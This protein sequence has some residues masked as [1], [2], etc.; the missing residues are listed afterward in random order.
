[1]TVRGIDN[2]DVH[3]CLHQLA[4]TVQNVRCHTNACT[5]KQPA[6][7]IL[8]AVGVLDLLLN[9]L[10]GD[11]SLQMA[12]LVDDRKLFLARLSEDL[13]GFLK[14]DTFLRGDQV[15]GRHVLGNLPG[16]ILLELEIAVRDDADQLSFRIH[17]RNTGD[18]VLSHQ[19]FGF[20]KGIVR[21][22]REGIRDDAVLGALD[23][24]DFFRLRFDRH[25]LV[26]DADSALACHSD[27]HTVFRHRIHAGAHDRNVEFDRLCQVC[28][29]VDLVRNHFRIGWN[30]QHV[31]KCNTLSNYFAQSSL[32]S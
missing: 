14:R 23:L 18:A 12:F 22:E 6:L 10:D 32:L 7:G 24:V 1:M 11:K 30:Q 31:I 20:L 21:S 27:G 29:E 16:E 4:D 25:V 13:L 17:D 9:I 15:L 8:C 2:H 3:M 26:D 28:R 19:V 5:C